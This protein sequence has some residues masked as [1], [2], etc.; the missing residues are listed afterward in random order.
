MSANYYWKPLS[1]YRYQA[2]CKVRCLYQYGTGS[3]QVLCLLEL[4]IKHMARNI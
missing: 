3:V 1:R 4:C 2:I